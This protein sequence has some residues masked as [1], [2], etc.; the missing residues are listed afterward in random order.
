M[1]HIA[2]QLALAW[3]P[4]Q[5]AAITANE[6]WGEE[7]QPKYLPQGQHQLHQGHTDEAQ[8]YCPQQTPQSTAELTQRSPRWGRG[9]NAFGGHLPPVPLASAA[10]PVQVVAISSVAASNGHAISRATCAASAQAS[11]ELPLGWAIFQD[12]RG[13]YYHCEGDGRTSWT[14]P[15]SHCPDGPAGIWRWTHSPSGDKRFVRVDVDHFRDWPPDVGDALILPLGW[16]ASW[17][18]ARQRH[19]YWNEV[20]ESTWSFPYD[21]SSASERQK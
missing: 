6:A 11:D 3:V 13:P 21:V 16:C 12:Q 14:R 8:Q 5:L 1:G 17:D 10:A 2:E 18:R 4:E 9:S 19:Y 15:N 7:D 20:G